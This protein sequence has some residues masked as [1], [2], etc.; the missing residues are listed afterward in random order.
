M[1]LAAYARTLNICHFLTGRFNAYSHLIHWNML[2]ILNLRFGRSTA[3]SY[4][5]GMPC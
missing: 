5:V 3:S 4:L 2:M 1:G